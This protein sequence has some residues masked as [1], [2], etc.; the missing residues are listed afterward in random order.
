MSFVKELYRRDPNWTDKLKQRRE[1]DIARMKFEK[2]RIERQV[3]L[4]HNEVEASKHQAE[5]ARQ[6]QFDI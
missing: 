2:D 1:Q 3:E 5:Q 4:K 6:M